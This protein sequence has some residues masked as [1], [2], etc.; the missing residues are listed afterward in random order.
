NFD[1]AGVSNAVSSLSGINTAVFGIVIT[2]V[3]IIVQ[4][5]AERYTGV[6]RM[7]LRDRINL[8]VSAYYVVACVAS[9][10]LSTALQA[11]YVPR[12]TLTAV[13]SVTTGGLIIMTPYFGYVFWLLEPRNIV[14]RIRQ[15]AV[16]RAT[17]GALKHD[18]ANCYAAQ[19][20]TLFALEELTDITNNSIS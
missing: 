17:S 8:L 16:A 19:A 5:T 3:S 11:D 15:D 6:W 2:V 4:L 18:E 9:V 10:W 7:F 13:L 1:P 20:Q 14:A 12:A